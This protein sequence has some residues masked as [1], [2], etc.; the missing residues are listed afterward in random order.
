[1][2]DNSPSTPDISGGP[3]TLEMADKWLSWLEDV[4]TLERD[5]GFATRIVLFNLFGEL[6]RK[7]LIDGHRLI[8]NLHATLPRLEHEG[9]RLALSLVIDDLAEQLQPPAPDV[10]ADPSRH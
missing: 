10:S 9:Q 7:G 8:K 5:A 1:M 6:A 4:A 2:N 3:L